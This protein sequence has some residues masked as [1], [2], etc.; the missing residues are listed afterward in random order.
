MWW[1][2]DNNEKGFFFYLIWVYCWFD[3]LP[4]S[5]S[6]C[7]SANLIKD[8][9]ALCYIIL[10]LSSLQLFLFRCY[11]IFVDISVAF[12]A[13]LIPIYAS[14]KCI[15]VEP[16]QSIIPAA[17]CP[18]GPGLCFHIHV[19]AAG[20]LKASFSPLNT[21][22]Q[23]CTAEQKHIVHH[24]SRSEHAKVIHRQALLTHT[25]HMSGVISPSDLQACA[26][27]IVPLSYTH[28]L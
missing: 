9:S 22:S 28:T 12:N 6:I 15:R 24:K 17:A 25:P 2:L 5:V 26:L 16:R 8:A 14:V 18:R 4:V 10:F 13:F 3:W 7:L 21:H 11:M 23:H 27:C 19:Q 20:Y 1:Q